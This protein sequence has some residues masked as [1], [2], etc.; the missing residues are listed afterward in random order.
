MPCGSCTSRPLIASSTSPGLMPASAAGPLGNSSFTTTPPGFSKPRLSAIS[1]LSASPVTP[2]HGRTSLPPFAS[3][4]TTARTMLE[5]MAKPMPIEP[6]LCEKIAVLMPTSLPSVVTSAPPELPGLIAASV[7]M[8]KP[9]SLMPVRVR[10][11]PETMPLVTVW[12][13]PNGLPIASTRSPTSRS[14][15]SRNGSV[16]SVA[17]LVSMRSSA[18]SICSSWAISLAA[19]SRPSLSTTRISSAPSMTWLLVTTRPSAS[20]M[21]PEPSAFWMRSRERPKLNSSPKN[22]LKNGSSKNGESACCFTTFLV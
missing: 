8:K 11:R 6:P 15:E 10:A 22:C 9:K 7:W 18:R 1:A 5:G 4:S 14:S 13:T 3:A 12:P 2:S 20:T 16:G 21:T 19:N 17:P